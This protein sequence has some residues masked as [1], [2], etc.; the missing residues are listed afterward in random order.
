MSDNRPDDP[1]TLKAMLLAEGHESK[2]LGEKWRCQPCQNILYADL[3]CRR[4]ECWNCG[5]RRPRIRLK[6][7][8]CR[9]DNEALENKVG[10]LAEPLLRRRSEQKG[11][12]DWGKDD[13]SRLRGMVECRMSLTLVALSTSQICAD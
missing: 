9:N 1:E 4:V 2:R 12:E 6:D 8:S 3:F 11:Q 13:D 7:A 10:G 5:K